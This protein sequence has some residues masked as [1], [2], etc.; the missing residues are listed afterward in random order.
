MKVEIGIVA[1]QFLFWEVLFRI[2]GICSLQC[3]GFRC[4]TN[5]IFHSMVQFSF[6][7]SAGVTCTKILFYYEKER[8]NLKLVKRFNITMKLDNLRNICYSCWSFTIL[9]E[10][11]GVKS[12]QHFSAY[13]PI[14]IVLQ[15]W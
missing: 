10:N 8:K 11:I 4:S 15:L 3:T 7:Y 5:K 9:H 1:V 12:T 2:F 13:S 14:V 6:V